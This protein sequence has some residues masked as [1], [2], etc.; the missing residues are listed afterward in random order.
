[1]MNFEIS[2]DM[3]VTSVKTDARNQFTEMII[4]MLKEKFGE[5]NVKMVRTG[6]TSKANEI[7]VKIGSVTEGGFEMPLVM[8]MK[9][10]VREFKDR[11]TA[12]K[13]YTAFDFERA[14]Q[15]YDDYLTEKATKKA[16]S[17]RAKAE[18]IARDTA[19]RTKEKSEAESID[20]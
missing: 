1:M 17:E 9:P 7:G 19:Q 6:G 14:A 5:D 20:F 13:T 10:S 12:R 2:K 15:D 11:T 8:T 16:N 3:T 4:E 18:K